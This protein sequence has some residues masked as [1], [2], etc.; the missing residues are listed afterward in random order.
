MTPPLRA[1]AAAPSRAASLALA[2]VLGLAVAVPPG[3]AWAQSDGRPAAGEP[4]RDAVFAV[5]VGHNGSDD[6][7]LADLRFADDDAL[8]HGAL[9][10]HVA[11]RVVVLARPDAETSRLDLPQPADLRAPTRDA[12][13]QALRDVRADAARARARGERPVLWFVYGGHGAIDSDGHGYVHLDG[14]RFTTRDVFDQIVRPADGDPVVMVVDAC[15]ASLLVHPRGA[16]AKRRPAGRDSLR[17]ADHP[18]VGVMLASSTAGETHEWGRYLSGIFSH[19]LRSA[20]VGPGDLDGDGR[21]TFAEVAAFVQRANARV[22]NPAVRIQPYVR[23]PL[24]APDL[25]LVDLGTAAF[26]ARLVLP[27]NFAGRAHVVDADLVRYADLHKAADRPMTIALPSGGP[28]ALVRGDTEYVVPVDAT[29]TVT[30]D[31]LE[32]RE[33]Q[34]TASRGATGAYLGRTLFVEAYSAAAAASY[35]E[36]RW[37]EDLTLESRVTTPWYD[38]DGAW[39]LL[40]SGLGVAALGAGLH[41]GA[42]DAQAEAREYVTWQERDRLNDRARDL[43]AGAIAGYAVGGAALIG[44]VL[45]FLLAEPEVATD[46]WAPP[47]QVDAGPGGVSVKARF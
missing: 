38:N 26:P 44:S 4:T 45:W 24:T 32:R 37:V 40:G 46:V 28:F 27:E 10:A 23:P 34:D 30:L 39:A 33:R 1:L 13:V 19:E 18:N 25:A 42:I 47:L 17:L 43:E 15:N 36:S 3:A 7:D 2:L 14:G 22:A 11:D 29:G 16:S 31:G 35:L 6:P 41:L 9:L 12:L 8:R 5:V 21:L 20:L